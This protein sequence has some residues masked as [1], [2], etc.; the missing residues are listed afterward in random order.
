MKTPEEFAHMQTPAGAGKNNVYYS[1]EVIEYLNE[2][3]D[4]RPYFKRIPM[5][6]ARAKSIK[7]KQ[8]EGIAAQIIGNAEVPR[9]RDVERKIYIELHRNA[10]GYDINFDDRIENADDPQFESREYQRSLER[11]DLKERADCAAVMIAGAGSGT[12][13]PALTFDV[14]V[15]RDAITDF[16][17]LPRNVRQKV[18]ADTIFLSEKSFR[19]IINSDQFKF[20]PDLYKDVL[21]RGDIGNVID[22]LKTVI[23]DELEDTIIIAA[24][25]EEPLWLAEGAGTI[26]SVYSDGRHMTDSV[27]FRH[28]EEAI[29]AYT[30]Y[31][32]AI[33]I[34]P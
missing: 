1:D 24:I 18:K 3:S 4:I 23:F 26:I 30:D 22:G 13:V 14:D 29:C 27:D 17:S 33:Q 5:G 34:V 20:I 12:S 7:I 19:K 8:K 11:L 31:L 32:A 16:N 15:V 21:L 10:S 9:A 25:R 6:T 2:I 28:D